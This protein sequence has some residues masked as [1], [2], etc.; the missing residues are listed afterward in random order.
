MD[1][2]ANTAEAKT[3]DAISRRL[4]FEDDGNVDDMFRKQFVDC[5]FL[6]VLDLRKSSIDN[7]EKLELQTF[8]A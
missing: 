6:L 7:L 8:S 5:S 4:T 2:E 3:E 1:S